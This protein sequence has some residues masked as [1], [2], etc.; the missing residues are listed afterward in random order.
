MNK[1][2]CMVSTKKSVLMLFILALFLSGG[3][4]P[5]IGFAQALSLNALSGFTSPSMT[6][7]PIF[8]HTVFAEGVVSPK[9]AS[10]VN[11][12]SDVKETLITALCM[13]RES[14]LI[15]AGTGDNTQYIY[16]YGYRKVDGVWK[17]ITYSGPKTIG[18]WVVGKATVQLE[19]VKEGE[20]G[21]VIAYICQKVAN[22]WKCGCSDKACSAP[23]WQLQQYEVS[24]DLLKS[25]QAYKKELLTQSIP[26]GDEL[27]LDIYT[28]SKDIALPGTKVE[29]SGSGFS[30]TNKND[31]LWNGVVKQVGLVSPNGSSLF[32][33]VPQLPPAKYTVTV[34]V[35][36]EV[37]EYGATIWIQAGANV[38]APV[39]HSIS[40][41]I[42]KQGGTFTI[43]GEGFTN[44]NDVVTTFSI[45]EGLPSKD[46]KSIT[47]SYDPFG[48]K[49][50]A[51]VKYG[52]P[53]HYKQQV[54]FKVINTSGTSNV[55][56]FSLD[57]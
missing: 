2:C 32:I 13:E 35:G 47:F 27:P 15:Q 30:K 43:Y 31:V 54:T 22:T 51:W 39:V 38:T 36:D 42:G 10:P 40:P 37:S 8:C 17:K 49:L 34:R 46:G 24:K 5:N 20:T 29:L 6:T 52:V 4:I 56:F 18:A 48:E 53:Y 16:K 23:K 25:A 12:F 11:F 41:K 9:F 3:G 57:I 7:I 19:G 28:S 50:E 44:N 1:T 45:L 26:T 21:E 55:S 33:T 14:V